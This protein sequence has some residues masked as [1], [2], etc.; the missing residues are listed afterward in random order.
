MDSTNDLLDS[1]ASFPILFFIF[2]FILLNISFP[3]AWIQT[4]ITA[5]F[6]NK[7]SK[8][9]ASFY[10]PVSLISMLCKLFDFILL[11]R[12]KKWFSPSDEQSAYQPDRSCA[13]NIFLIRCLISCVKRN[14]QKLFLIAV[15]FEGAFDKVNRT[16]LFKK[17][18]RFGAGALYIS[19]LK[20][21]YCRTE[22]II[23]GNKGSHATYLTEAGIKQGSPMSP[24]LFLFYV[25]DIFA[26]FLGTF[27]SRCIY[28]TVHILMHADDAVLLASSRS[29]AIL[30]VKHLIS[31]CILNS[32]KLEP[33]KSHFIVIN[34][35]DNDTQPLV[36]DH[37]S[38]SNSN[39]ISLLGSHLSASG[40]ISDDLKLHYDSRFKAAIKYY[41]FLRANRNAPLF[42]RLK[43][44][45]SCVLSNILYNCETFGRDIPKDLEKCYL[46]L[47]KSCLGIRR[48]TPS[49]LVLIESGFLSLEAVV[50]GRQLNFFRK[51][52]IPTVNKVPLIQ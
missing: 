37:G 34:G 3:S 43:V 45:K 33:S 36:T 20:A 46:S 48:N 2:N 49:H 10:R 9:F 47:I 40:L 15:D 52:K 50:Y 27:S 51:L 28:E 21:I 23:F 22:Y 16:V 42:I 19:C 25:D 7:G 30:K 12:F 1:T 14:K 26:F 4:L 5:I 13:D 35:E 29:L 44:L 6:K 38:I 8:K 18:V 41:N 11:N 32:I 24:Y 17:L 39:H 31:Y